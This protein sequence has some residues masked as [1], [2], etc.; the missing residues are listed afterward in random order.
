MR[1][2]LG[3]CLTAI[4]LAVAGCTAAGD[5]PVAPREEP[6]P[7][8]ELRGP[9][10]TV[11]PRPAVTEAPSSWLEAA[12]A[13]PYE[14]VVRIRRGYYPNRS[15]EVIFVPREPNFMGGFTSTTHSGP[16]DYVQDVPLVFYG[17]GFIRDA[18][19]IT[20]DREVTVADLAPTLAELL[21][22]PWPGGR[23]GRAITEALLPTA[24]RP[25]PPKMILVVVWDGGG[26]DVLDTWP[27]AWPNL[28]RMMAH[29]TSVAGA[30]V[31][32]SPSVTPAIHTTIGTGTF[33]KE[34]GIVDIPVRDGLEVVGSYDDI[35]PQY[36][37]VPTLADLYDRRTAN[38][39]KIGM[40][41]YKPWHLGMIGHGAYVPGGDHDIAIIS[42]R[43]QGDLITNYDW[44]SLPD[45]LH[46]TPG[47]EA[48]V[49]AVDDDDGKIDSKWMGHE[50][51]NDANRLRHTPVWALFQTRLLKSVVVNEGYGDDDV[52]DMFWT[53]YKQIDDVGHD[54]NML[55]PEM[56]EILEYSDL[57]LRKLEKFLDAE[58]GRNEWV[59]AFTADHGQSPDPLAVGAWPIRIQLLQDDVAEH[60]GVT[61]EDLFQDERPVGFWI[62]PTFAAAEGITAEDVADFL[63]RYR[64]RDNL[65]PGEEPPAKY[66]DRLDELVFAAAL[67]SARMGKIWRC[68]NERRG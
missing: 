32:S 44:Y 11:S 27:N 19:E 4:A 39:A 2:R 48:D 33:P 55:N 66:R 65:R 50:V 68:V 10:A 43:S 38:V 9:W 40:F 61:A 67:P 58:V 54:W 30:T 23:P 17:P 3:A 51:L 47:F 60:F 46:D 7:A 64:L 26:W 45:Y 15:P 34:H 37:E 8:V 25:D 14:H 1:T 62:D 53:N 56:R 24:D 57:E 12:C 29:G 59:I 5:E 18:G 31:G 49:R 16:W 6:P 22:T 20:L 63:V 35:T 52:T 13:L 36:L 28:R 21:E 41:A 42:E